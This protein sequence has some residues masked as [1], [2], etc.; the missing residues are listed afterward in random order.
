M[1]NYECEKC[2]KIFKQMGHYKD[3]LNR[4][5]PCVYKETEKESNTI[6]IPPKL[7]KET[8]NSAKINT[9]NIKKLMCNFCFREFKRSDYLYKHLESRCKIRKHE[10]QKNEI[11]IQELIKKE[12]ERIEIQKNNEINEL[13]N[14][15]N[16]LKKNKSSEKVNI[17]NNKT[18]NNKTIN[19]NN[20]IV[21]NINIKIDF[22]KEDLDKI[23]N[24]EIYMTIMKSGIDNIHS[25]I[26]EL[27]HLNN[28]YSEFQN[29][30]IS[31]YNR[32]LG[33]IMRNNEFS[34]VT[35]EELI[36]NLINT[37]YELLTKRDTIIQEKR[38]K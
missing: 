22:G 29:C 30:Y 10:I 4:K 35:G 16:E 9:E 5:R 28:N 20:G 6:H 24:S 34:L 31:D 19:N 23:T 8:A 13:K 14:V 21:N 17:N 32:N 3:H 18:I 15:I 37:N 25:K 26:T 2:G 12:I 1:V 11:I 33:Y 7:P 27:I 38:N 36:T